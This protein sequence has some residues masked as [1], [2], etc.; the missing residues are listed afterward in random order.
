MTT[1]SQIG[2]AVN[3]MLKS[4]VTWSAK[5]PGTLLLWLDEMDRQLLEGSTVASLQAHCTSYEHLQHPVQLIR[6]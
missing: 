6:V 5:S 1:I 4:M 2:A 3:G